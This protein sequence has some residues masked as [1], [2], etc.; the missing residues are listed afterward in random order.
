MIFPKMTMSFVEL[1]CGGL[2]AVVK[3]DYM[4][5]SRV[6]QCSL[7]IHILGG[8]RWET[9]KRSQRIPLTCLLAA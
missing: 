8:H 5:S 7:V 3:G 6:L 9:R 1:N 2:Q 4:I